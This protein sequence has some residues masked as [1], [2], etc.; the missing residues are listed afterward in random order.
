MLS[1]EKTVQWIEGQIMLG[2]LHLAA[3]PMDQA[4]DEHE[5]LLAV[6]IH[7]RT[8][9]LQQLLAEIEEREFLPD[10]KPEG[11]GGDPW[12][13]DKTERSW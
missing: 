10:A 1:I 8:T 3:Q 11:E 7:A 5:L 2:Q 9:T 13:G 4:K 6:S 12:T